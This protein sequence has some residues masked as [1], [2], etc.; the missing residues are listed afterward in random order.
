MIHCGT[1]N[2]I[3]ENFTRQ[4]FEHEYSSSITNG[5]PYSGG[6]GFT[7]AA[8]ECEGE[9]VSAPEAATSDDDDDGGDADPDPARR[10]LKSPISCG[11]N[12]NTTATVGALPSSPESKSQAL[13]SS[14]KL[15]VYPPL[16]LINR[17][18][19][20]TAQAAYYLD[21]KPQT[22]RIWAL[23]EYPIK[24]LRINGR[25]AWKVAD[26]KRLLGVA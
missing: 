13:T 12:R 17:P 4:A 22:M 21:R 25:L 19:V 8:I 16:D 26:L 23:R 7:D 18:T 11:K 6:G 1:R 20:P 24:P 5:F 15:I 3:Y 9:T 14:A 2:S 10:R